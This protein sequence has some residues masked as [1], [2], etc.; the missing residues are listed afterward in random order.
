MKDIMA[1]YVKLPELEEYREWF[2]DH[3]DLYREDGIL[4]VTMKTN[5]HPMCWSGANHRAMSQL[6][7]I[8]SLDRKNEILI[9]THKGDNWMMDKDPHGWSTY[10]KER[11]DHQYIDDTNLIKLS[12]IHI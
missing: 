3:F 9:W 10:A 11:F 1:D 6:S 8:I 5:D 12:L 7:R 2:K 4:Q